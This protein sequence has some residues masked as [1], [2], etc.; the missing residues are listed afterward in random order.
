MAEAR[1]I[2]L[3]VHQYCAATLGVAAMSVALTV[4]EAELAL[5][6]ARADET[7]AFAIAA[8]SLPFGERKWHPGA[9]SRQAKTHRRAQ[10][11]QAG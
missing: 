11:C 9:A 6:G 4:L 3:L 8:A 5:L 2:A 10:R 1:K 7:A